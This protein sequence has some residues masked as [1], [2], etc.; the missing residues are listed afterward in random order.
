VVW[1][2]VLVADAELAALAQTVQL[3][4][5]LVGFAGEVRRL[6]PHVTLARVRHPKPVEAVL[7]ALGDDPIGPRFDVT[8]VVLFESRTRREGAVHTEVARLALGSSRRAKG[9]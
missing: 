4:T 1:A 3:A 6:H 2:G 9:A 5:A 7:A 8:E